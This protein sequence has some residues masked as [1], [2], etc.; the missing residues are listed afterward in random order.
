MN[1][2]KTKGCAGLRSYSTS[3]C[4]SLSARVP[5]FITIPLYLVWVEERCLFMLYCF[6]RLLS[7][8]VCFLSLLEIDLEVSCFNVNFFLPQMDRAGYL[9]LCTKISHTLTKKQPQQEANRQIKVT[10]CSRNS[11]IIT[12]TMLRGQ[13]EFSRNRFVLII[14]LLFHL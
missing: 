1:E 13:V 14:I 2:H 5:I 12:W 6:L 11:F 9:H 3:R 7:S 8:H 10:L 4:A